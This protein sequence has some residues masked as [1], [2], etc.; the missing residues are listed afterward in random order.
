MRLLEELYKED[1]E[2]SAAYAMYR[3]YMETDIM[4]DV[5]EDLVRLI[6]LV[7]RID[8]PQA[9]GGDDMIYVADALDKC[10]QVLAGRPALPSETDFKRYFWT[11]IRR[12][13][14]DTIRETFRPD[15]DFGW[16]GT[17]PPQGKMHAY[18]DMMR[19]V[20][21][22]SMIEAARRISAT[23]IRF[24]GVERRVCKDLVE[25]LIDSHPNPRLVICDRYGINKRRYIFF[26]R[27]SQILVRSSYYAVKG[28]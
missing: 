3:F 26:E 10:F 17:L 6:G 8:F 19:R 16:H 1:F 27:Y 12:S 9:P 5:L 4:D 21:F 7:L 18:E 23:K 14:I 13:M 20:Q 11:V 25:M 24:T 22:K 2:A 15:Y 28:A